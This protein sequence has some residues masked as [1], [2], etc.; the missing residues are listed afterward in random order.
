MESTASTNN[1]TATPEPVSTV[2]KQNV[3]EN[4]PTTRSLN[5]GVDLDWLQQQ[6][7]QEFPE[8]TDEDEA[9]RSFIRAKRV[10]N[11]F[12][13]DEDNDRCKYGPSKSSTFRVLFKY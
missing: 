3:L 13:L 5:E 9:L 10:G 1:T 4:N 7:K 6:A 8:E 12:F 11:L 2:P